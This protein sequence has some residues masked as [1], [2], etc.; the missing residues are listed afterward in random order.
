MRELF[1]QTTLFV[2]IGVIAGNMLANNIL[3]M[4]QGR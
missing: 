4:T 3:N 2:D 1:S